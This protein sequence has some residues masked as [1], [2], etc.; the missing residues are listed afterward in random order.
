M[1]ELAFLGPDPAHNLKLD[2]TRQKRRMA[3]NSLKVLSGIDPKSLSFNALME[4]AE[5]YLWMAAME[6]GYE[7]DAKLYLKEAYRTLH[8]NQK[9]LKTDSQRAIAYGRMAKGWAFLTAL[10]QGFSMV[11]AVKQMSLSLQLGKDGKES[12]DMYSEGDWS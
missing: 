3:L 12:V 9:S 11:G 1:D 8:F 10:S 4:I 6:K 2:K 5:A 7:D